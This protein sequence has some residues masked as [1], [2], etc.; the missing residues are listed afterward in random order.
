MSSV[1]MALETNSGAMVTREVHQVI[2]TVRFADM[3]VY[4]WLVMAANPHLS[5]PDIVSVILATGGKHSFRSERWLRKRRCMV[6]PNSTEAPGRRPNADGDGDRAL[7][8]MRAN[9]EMSIRD[10]ERLL[11]KHGIDRG[12][13]WVRIHRCD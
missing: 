8:I 2:Q 4:P 1:M 10:L 7:K 6:Q 5:T 12:R 13:E 11:K 9:T 3:A